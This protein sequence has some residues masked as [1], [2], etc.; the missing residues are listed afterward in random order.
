M[1]NNIFLIYYWS[2]TLKSLNNENYA[3]SLY[4]LNK[5]SKNYIKNNYMFFSVRSFVYFK[6]SL[7]ENS[8]ID[9]SKAIRL[10]QKSKKLNNDEKQYLIYCNKMILCLIKSIS[11]TNIDHP[12]KEELKNI[13]Y[14]IENLSKKLFRLPCLSLNEK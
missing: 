4:Y 1:I 8:Q 7:Y 11:T 2:K 13:Q 5:V 14:N 6:L 10:I 12:C 9:A 3:E